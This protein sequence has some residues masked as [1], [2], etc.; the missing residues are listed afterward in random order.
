M[1][2]LNYVVLDD[3]MHDNRIASTR[4]VFISNLMRYLKADRKYQRV[5]EVNC[6]GRVW[7]DYLLESPDEYLDHLNQSIDA[8]FSSLTVLRKEYQRLTHARLFDGSIGCSRKECTEEEWASFRPEK[9]EVL[10]EAYTYLSLRLQKSS[11]AQ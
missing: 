1:L 3:I 7:Q 5:T 6:Y 10:D 8:A 11:Q 9:A 4:K 2:E